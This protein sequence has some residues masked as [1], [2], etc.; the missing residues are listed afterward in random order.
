VLDIVE[1]P[2]TTQAKGEATSCFRVR[3]VGAL[4][5]LEII[6]R[7]PWR[8]AKMRVIHLDWLTLLGEMFSV[9]SVLRLYNDEHLR[10]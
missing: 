7:S 3:D 4:V 2:A 1:E 9:R 8:R 6:A 10:L 5:T